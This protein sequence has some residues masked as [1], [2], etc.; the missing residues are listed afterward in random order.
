MKKS[1]FIGLLVTLTIMMMGC[2]SGRTSD[3]EGMGLK[4]N[5]E[6]IEHEFT[7]EDGRGSFSMYFGST[8]V[9]SE[10]ELEFN[11]DGFLVK[12][13]DFVDGE[14]DGVFKVDVDQN[15]YP[16]ESSYKADDYESETEFESKDDIADI[17]D[18]ELE[19]ESDDGAEVVYAYDEQGRLVEESYEYEDGYS[20]VYEFAYEDGL[21]SSVEE[22]IAD[23]NNIEY[24]FIY[25]KE[26]RVGSVINNKIDDYEIE[27]EFKY[28]DE[29]KKGNW[30]KMEVYLEDELI[31]TFERSYTYY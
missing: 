15:G 16:L 2:S 11:E 29:D 24:E 20:I 13:T 28:T 4:G 27:Y 18:G 23:L 14:K 10:C 5:I 22:E 9:T 12:R 26:T 3:L 21:V 30:T 7:F 19:G 25:D 31:G 6:S 1:L 8:W 17:E